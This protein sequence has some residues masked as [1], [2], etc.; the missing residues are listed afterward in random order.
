M[1]LE[2]KYGIGD[3]VYLATTYVTTK[4]H[5]CPD[6]L[7]SK[8]WRA[9]SPA[10][11]EYQFPCPRCDTEAYHNYRETSLEYTTHEP[12]AEPLTIGKLEYA[13]VK[14]RGK[15]E[16]EIRYMCYETGVGSGTIYDESRL[17]PSREEAELAA[18]KFAEELNSKESNA[19]KFKD[20]LRICDYHL[21]EALREARK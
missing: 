9:I 12:Q 5:K 11:D 10:G 1:K 6:C 13:M 18:S 7:G 2:T 21:K 19:A 14:K 8:F 4:K 3:R 16:V 17:F 15:E 20:S